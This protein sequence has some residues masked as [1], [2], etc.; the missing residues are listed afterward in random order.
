MNYDDLTSE[1]FITDSA[2]VAQY[3]SIVRRYPAARS[4]SF[5]KVEVPK[6]PTE[7]FLQMT[8]KDQIFIKCELKLIVIFD[9]VG[10]QVLALL[11]VDER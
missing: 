4:P 8:L 3:R 7:H 2:G 5:N 6:C 11:L 10:R 9:Y 1:S